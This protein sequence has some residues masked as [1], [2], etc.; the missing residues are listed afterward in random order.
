MATATPVAA[1]LA[2]KVPF[3]EL[4][5]YRTLIVNLTPNRQGTSQIDGI[6]GSLL[7]A[8]SADAKP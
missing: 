8:P 3:L 1:R 2:P 7:P 5:T 4:W 6:V